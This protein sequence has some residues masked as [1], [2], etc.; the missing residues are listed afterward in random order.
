MQYRLRSYKDDKIYA[1]NNITSKKYKATIDRRINNRNWT[2][3][4]EIFLYLLWGY[5]LI[6][7]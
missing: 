5:I 3:N 6:K 7:S 2:F 4:I 1:P